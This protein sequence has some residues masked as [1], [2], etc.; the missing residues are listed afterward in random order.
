MQRWLVHLLLFRGDGWVACIGSLVVVPNI[1]GSL[2]NPHLFGIHEGWI[3]VLGV[4][5]LGGMHL[6]T[7]KARP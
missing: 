6:R 3:Y 4:G 2:F 7:K 5:I 1:F